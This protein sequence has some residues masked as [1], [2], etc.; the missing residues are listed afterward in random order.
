MRNINTGAHT[1]LLL[2]VQKIFVMLPNQFV[3]FYSI[4][5][6]IVKHILFLVTG[7]L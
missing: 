5:I 2:Y 4:K 3:M 6:K 7:S 1:V